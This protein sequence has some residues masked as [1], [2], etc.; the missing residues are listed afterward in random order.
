MQRIFSYAATATLMAMIALVGRSVHAASVYG[1]LYEVGNLT[2]AT[3]PG[4]NFESVLT[5]HPASDG[6]IAIT[7]VESGEVEWWTSNALG[8]AWTLSETNP[9]SEYNCLQPGRH[10][11]HV[12]EDQVYFTAACEDGAYVFKL[13]G[14]ESVEL[15]HSITTAP[16]YPTTTDLN[17]TLYFFFNGGFT[18]FDGS[19]WTDVTTAANQPEGVP[20]EASIEDDGVLYLAFTTGEVA[21]FDGASYTILNDPSDGMGS[22]PSIEVFNDTIYVGNSVAADEGEGAQLFK[23]DVDDVDADGELWE[24]VTQ[25]D[26]ENTIINKMQI[27]QSFDGNRYLVYFTSNG[28]EG[29]NIVAMDED[30]QMIDLV[31]AGLGGTNPENNQEVVDVVRR[32]VTVDDVTHHVMLFST[33]NYDDETKVFILELGDDFAYTPLD[34]HFVSAKKKNKADIHLSEGSVLKVKVPKKK[35]S[36]GDVFTLWIDGEK[37]FS[38]TAKTGSSLTLR[39]KAAKKLDSGD[40]FTL[41]VGRRMSYG[42]GKSQVLARN[43]IL[44]DELLVKVD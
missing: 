32:D 33:Q 29:T 2:S 20:L 25:L 43:T 23:Y 38:K 39:Y 17:G 13:T 19:S 18:S 36:K 35:V 34:G 9:L 5:Y 37:V 24:E 8:T 16:G 31:D 7:T 44:G 40:T 3:I 4:N 28:T 26:S 1:S 10:G 15:L 14:T 27:S 42:T 11:T 30:E 21:S 12:F 41:Q 22:L 6:F